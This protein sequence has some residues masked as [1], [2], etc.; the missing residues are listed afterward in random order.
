MPPN[1]ALAALLRCPLHALVEPSCALAASGAFILADSNDGFI[2]PI[3][4][5][6]FEVGMRFATQAVIFSIREIPY[7]V[8]QRLPMLPHALPDPSQNTW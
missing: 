7:Q 3:G 5:V 2:V 8:D 1:A 4:P 6:T